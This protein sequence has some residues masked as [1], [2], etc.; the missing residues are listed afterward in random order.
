[1]G[2]RVQD[3]RPV[4]I[5]S[6]YQLYWTV[7]DDNTPPAAVDFGT[8]SEVAAWA[9]AVALVLAGADVVIT[10]GAIASTAC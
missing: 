5:P 9:Q 8:C 10:I 1:M 4:P 7:R 2:V 3:Y 6:G